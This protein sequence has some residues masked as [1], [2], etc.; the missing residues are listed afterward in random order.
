MV[1]I[2]MSTCCCSHLPVIPKLF[3]IATTLTTNSVYKPVGAS[4]SKA[5]AMNEV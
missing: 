3:Y 2:Y 1:I 4:A 5:L